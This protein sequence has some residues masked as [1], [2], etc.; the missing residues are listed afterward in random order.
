MIKTAALFLKD[1][2]GKKE[3][4]KKKKKKKIFLP[5]LPEIFFYVT[6][7]TDIFFFGLSLP[8]FLL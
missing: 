1:K 5:T 6:G 8:G 2:E 7:N 3:K 4:K